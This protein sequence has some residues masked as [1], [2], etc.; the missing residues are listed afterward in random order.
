MD[1]TY[2]GTSQ[3]SFVCGLDQKKAIVKINKVIERSPKFIFF[4]LVIIH[5]DIK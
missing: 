1:L 2:F 4:N 3:E 5:K